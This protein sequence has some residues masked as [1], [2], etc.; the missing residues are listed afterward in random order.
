[1]S[2]RTVL[3]VLTLLSY[4]SVSLLAQRQGDGFTLQEVPGIALVKPQSWSKDTQATV[5]EFSG[6]IDRSAV[7][8]GGAG[9]Y[10]FQ[11]PSGQR[12]QVEVGRVLKVV[13]YPDPDRVQ[14]LLDARDREKVEQTL[15]ELEKVIA[16][17]PS[18]RSFLADKMK[19]FATL[20]QNYEAGKVKLEGQWIPRSV[21]VQSQAQRFAKLVQEDIE[22]ASPPGSH[23]LNFDPK[24]QELLVLAKDSPA[25]KALAEQL[26]ARNGELARRER[27][28]QILE[29]LEEGELPLTA[30][31][32]LIEELAKLKP[33]EDEKAAQVLA[34]WQKARLDA[35]SL[36]TLAATLGEKIDQSLEGAVAEQPLVLP[37]ET[38]VAVSGL[39]GKVEAWKQ[40]QAPVQLQEIITPAV[41]VIAAVEIARQAGSLISERQFF[42]LQELLEAKAGSAMQT[43][44]NT[45]QFLEGL[46]ALTTER[47]EAFV[48]VR[49]AAKQLAE[50]GKTEEAR[51]KYE[52]ALAIL[53][54]DGVART[55]QNL[56]SPTSKPQ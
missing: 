20:L 9:Y 52:E 13:E 17:F 26:K 38:V 40:S 37:E 24:Y 8:H 11:L 3:P 56:G 41:A 32:K 27:R 28:K 34:R 12:R 29:K 33:E 42:Q 54:D 49:E 16:K 1:M 45:R 51:G 21:Y 22:A 10:E 25:A 39:Q 19:N 7:G 18:T 35:E 2:I 44:P 53:A 14:T 4:S 31:N 43:G 36:A 50:Q 30:C 6:Y 46:R 55:L 23:D 5:M 48:S 15:A 47:V